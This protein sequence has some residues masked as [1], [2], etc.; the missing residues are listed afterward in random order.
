M[1]NEHEM[2]I[3]SSLPER[4]LPLEDDVKKVKLLL[5]PCIRLS[6]TNVSM[7]LIK[8]GNSEFYGYDTRCDI[9]FD[10]LKAFVNIDSSRHLF[11]LTYLFSF[12]FAMFV[13]I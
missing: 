8:D 11:F 2:R 5:N 13:T 6:N 7:I 3:E 4:Q 9:L 1:S 12:T 10:L